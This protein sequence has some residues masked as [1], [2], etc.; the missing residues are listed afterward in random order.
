MSGPNYTYNASVPQAAQLIKVTQAPILSNFQAIN[1]LITV[2]HVGFNDPI[3][4][5]KHTFTTFPLQSVNPSTSSTDIALFTKSASTSNGIEI[6][7]RYPSNGT[8]YQLTGGG[9]TSLAATNGYCY[10][11]S[12]LL[13]K[14]GLAS[15]NT[16]GSTVVSFPTAGGIPAFTTVCNFVQYTPA[17]NYTMNSNGPWIS[18]FNTTSFTFNAP[19][20]G[21]FC[22]QIYWFAIGV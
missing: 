19:S 4:Y 8:V 18:T 20:G 16:T 13:M 10:L 5:G 7:Y 15:I 1:E 9:T 17:A 3:N 11:T 6:F 21:T 2:N 22:N 12:T 14:W